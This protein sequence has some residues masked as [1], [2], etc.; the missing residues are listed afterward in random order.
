MQESDKVKSDPGS[1]SRRAALPRSGPTKDGTPFAWSM[2]WG[3]ALPGG[4]L[5]LDSAGPFFPPTLRLHGLLIS[6]Q[7]L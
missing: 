7:T 3:V 4:T 2:A 1:R 6:F 5:R